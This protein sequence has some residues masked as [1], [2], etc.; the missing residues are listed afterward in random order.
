MGTPASGWCNFGV[1]L[2]RSQVDSC[3]NYLAQVSMLDGILA[4]GLVWTSKGG[5][6]FQKAMVKPLETVDGR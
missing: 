3:G 6:S 4:N 1:P 5:D 2:K